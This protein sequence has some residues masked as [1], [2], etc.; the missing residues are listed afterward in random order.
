MRQRRQSG[1][2]ADPLGLGYSALP[3]SHRRLRAPLERTVLRR[4]AAAH[5]SRRCSPQRALNYFLYRDA[6]MAGP[7]GC[8]R[9]CPGALKTARLS[10]RFLLLGSDAIGPK[11]CAVR[12][13]VILPCH[14]TMP[15]RARRR[16]AAAASTAFPPAAVRCVLP[17]MQAAY[18]INCTTASHTAHTMHTSLSPTSLSRE[19]GVQHCRLAGPLA[20]QAV[21]RDVVGCGALWAQGQ[22]S[23]NAAHQAGELEAV[24]AARAAQHHL[25]AG[26][27]GRL[28]RVGGGTGQETS[29]LEGEHDGCALMHA[30]PSHSQLMDAVSQAKQ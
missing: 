9:C 25:Q 13:W 27:G 1:G 2:G 30:C 8:C 23:Q 20:R 17:R 6:S 11:M 3:S 4:S 19:H 16:R 29:T 26:R 22:V 10:R 24:S 7:I 14:V 12:G 15:R 18:N 28:R 21:Q 5:L